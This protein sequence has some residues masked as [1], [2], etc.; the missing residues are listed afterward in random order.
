M[1]LVPHWVHRVPG[2][3][4]VWPRGARRWWWASPELREHRRPGWCSWLPTS[5]HSNLL[6]DCPL[7]A[8]YCYCWLK[9]RYYWTGTF[10]HCNAFRESANKLIDKWI[11]DF[12]MQ[13]WPPI[14]FLHLPQVFY[15]K[16]RQR[17]ICCLNCWQICESIVFPVT[18]CHLII[19]SKT[20]RE[21]PLSTSYLVWCPAQP[22]RRSPW[23]IHWGEQ[24]GE[25]WGWQPALFSDQDLGDQSSW[26]PLK[27]TYI[28]ILTSSWAYLNP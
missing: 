11:L 15:T 20:L 6:G 14:I 7:S 23:C 21:S 17:L 4:W 16:P 12:W 26:F 9:Y 28:S 3:V 8:Q 2:P 22:Q 5:L 18:R 25:L 24:P 10:Y 1:Y 27:F 13:S 19:I